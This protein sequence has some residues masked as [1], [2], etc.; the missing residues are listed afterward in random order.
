M[1]VAT[2][3]P[4]KVREVIDTETRAEIIRTVRE[5]SAFVNGKRETLRKTSEIAHEFGVRRSYVTNALRYL[6]QR[7]AEQ[8]ARA[9]AEEERRKAEEEISEAMRRASEVVEVEAPT[10][11]ELPIGVYST[12]PSEPV[13]L[14]SRID[15]LESL[16]ELALARLVRIEDAL[17]AVMERVNAIGQTVVDLDAKWE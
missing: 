11:P 15:K 5:C 14:A 8:A 16:I 3:K 13:M 2:T 6:R 12:V 17:S 4:R 9:R 10:Q 7:D 1:N